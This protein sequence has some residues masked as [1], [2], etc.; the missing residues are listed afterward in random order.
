[1]HRQHVQAFTSPRGDASINY[2]IS[3]RRSLLH[4]TELGSG[5][6]VHQASRPSPEAGC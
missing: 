4:V 1:M 5:Q 6:E 2:P 3:Q